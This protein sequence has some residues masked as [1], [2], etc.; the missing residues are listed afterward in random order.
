MRFPRTTLTLLGAWCAFS[1]TAF[2]QDSDAAPP[3]HLA[4]VD[5]T[6]TLDREDVTEPAAGGAVMMAGPQPLPS[7][8]MAFCI[9]AWSSGPTCLFSITTARF[10]I[11]AAQASAVTDAYNAALLASLPAGVH[12]YDTAALKK[13]GD[14]GVLALVCDSTNALVAG[15]SGSEAKVRESLTNLIGTLKG[16]VAVTSFASNVACAACASACDAAIVC[17]TSWRWL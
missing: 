10:T 4:I 5:G 17:S 7:L 1:P 15:E 6:A 3:P 9:P 16:R 8:S 14:E 11:A 12:F 2:A 13:L